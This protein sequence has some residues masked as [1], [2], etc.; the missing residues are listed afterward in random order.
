MRRINQLIWLDAGHGGHDSGARSP[1]GVKESDVVLVVCQ[2]A[3]ERLEALGF[4]VMMSRES[5]VFIP[6]WERSSMAND[7]G[8]DLFVSAHANAA[9]S[10]ASGIETFAMPGSEDGTRLASFLQDAQLD[11]FPDAKDRGVKYQ[12]FS[13]L[14]K[15]RMPAALVELEFI[16]TDKGDAH[17]RDS[18]NIERHADA[19]V[20][21]VCSY[22]GVDVAVVSVGLSDGLSDFEAQTR[23]VVDGLAL[24]EEFE[25][26]QQENLRLRKVAADLR[27]HV[28]MLLELNKAANQKIIKA[29]KALN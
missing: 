21:G 9:D 2:L 12:G 13:V 25:D 23:E 15:T 27:A 6:L 28:A 16:H 11:A 26:L 29:R 7:A 17:F 5:D 22:V 24:R 19:L 10:V 18:E 14:R 1:S 8:A 20:A 3:K 4:R